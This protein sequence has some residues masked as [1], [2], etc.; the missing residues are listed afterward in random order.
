MMPPPP[1]ILTTMLLELLDFEMLKFFSTF[2]HSNSQKSTLRKTPYLFGLLESVENF[3]IRQ[4]CF[5]YSLFPSVIFAFE[6]VPID[7]STTAK[8]KYL[9]YIASITPLADREMILP[10]CCPGSHVAC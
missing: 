6:E 8:S 5:D 10:T 3:E 4:C 1:T 9:P 2:E 7:S